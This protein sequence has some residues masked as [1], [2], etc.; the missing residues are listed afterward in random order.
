[1]SPLDATLKN[2]YNA[3][4]SYP[5]TSMHSLSDRRGDMLHSFDLRGPNLDNCSST[6]ASTHRGG[7]SWLRRRSSCSRNS[8]GGGGGGSRTNSH[9]FVCSCCSRLLRAAISSDAA[10]A[11]GRGQRIVGCGSHCSSTGS[12]VIAS[13]RRHLL[14]GSVAHGESGSV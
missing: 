4:V 11:S 5:S 13:A 12:G 2:N 8:G 6:T 10:A 3:S 9:V 14:R 7:S 1:M